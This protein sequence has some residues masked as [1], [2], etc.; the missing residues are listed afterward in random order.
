M[1]ISILGL[2]AYAIAL[3]KV[4]NKNENKVVMWSK[5][6]DEVDSVLLKR[7]NNAV[8]PGVKIPKDIKITKELQ[9]C[10]KDAKIIVLA[11]PVNALRDV[12]KELSNYLEK[13][14]VLCLVS[15]GIESLSNKLV[16]EVVYEET[17]SEQ[18]CFLTGPSFA[19]EIVEDSETGFVVASKSQFANMSVKVC[20]ENGK[21]AVNAIYDIV[22]A[23]VCAATKNVFA[24]LM[25]MLDTLKKSDSCKAAILTCMINDLRKIVEVLGGKSHTV[26]SY[27]GIGDLVLTCISPKSRNYTL[28]R[29]LGRGI[30]LDNALSNMKVKTVEGLYTL[31]SLL[32][33][34]EQKEITIKSLSLL[35]NVI[36]R[37]E[38]VEDILRYIK[39]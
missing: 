16:H 32:K 19:E 13:D 6:S 3:A 10:V 11:V 30:G 15:K 23:E 29:H 12:A 37:N 20:L 8:L 14:Q 21:I 25:G 36:Y 7:E 34:L 1:K 35:Y 9:E 27:A 31:E 18:I 5:F 39:Y 33:L 24:I 26:F 22:G 4:F 2:G 28:G 17:N 38:K